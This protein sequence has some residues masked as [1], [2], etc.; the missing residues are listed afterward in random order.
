MYEESQNKPS[1]MYDGPSLVSQFEENDL[2]AIG[3]T[4]ISKYETIVGLTGTEADACM[5]F[6]QEV[7]LS[8]S[9]MYTSVEPWTIVD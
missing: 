9:C 2:A 1:S 7:C 8:K 3:S 4:M 6:L 5:W